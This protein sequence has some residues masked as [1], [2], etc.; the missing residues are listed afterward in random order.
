MSSNVKLGAVET[1]SV[2]ASSQVAQSA[3]GDDGGAVGHR[4]GSEQGKW[5]HAMGWTLVIRY[6]ALV[7]SQ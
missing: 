5:W 7:I 2:A 3:G 4:T 6:I 1:E